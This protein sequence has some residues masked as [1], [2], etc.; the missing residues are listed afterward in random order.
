LRLRLLG[1]IFRPQAEIL[2]LAPQIAPGTEGRFPA[3]A[4]MPSALPL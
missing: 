1:A 2:A 4:G 3:R